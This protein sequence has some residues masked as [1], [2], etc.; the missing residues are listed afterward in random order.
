MP[1]TLPSMAGIGFSPVR[2]FARSRTEQAHSGAALA[3]P[4]SRGTTRPRGEPLD[5]GSALMPGLPGQ[6][7]L[8]PI[9]PFQP[10]LIP[11][12]AGVLAS[13]LSGSCWSAQGQHQALGGLSSQLCRGTRVCVCV[14][15]CA[16]EAEKC[17]CDRPA[18]ASKTLT[19]ALAL[20]VPPSPRSVSPSGCSERGGEGERT[21]GGRSG[22]ESRGQTGEAGCRALAVSHSLSTESA[23][24]QELWLEIR[25][26]CIPLALLLEAVTPL[27]TR[28]QT[29][30]V[31]RA[32]ERSAWTLP[33]LNASMCL[34]AW[35]GEVTDVRD[36]G[37]RLA[38][39]SPLT[40]SSR[41]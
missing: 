24:F 36:A 30:S 17:R 26:V 25:S 39:E 8:R 5:A 37:A 11:P 2:R 22:T 21:E 18:G 1:V 35:G 34:W 7:P 15:V 31:G 14:C 32:R 20:P 27:D 33:G 4:P 16:S 9:R 12:S 29:G 3:R 13:E 23:C 41:Q 6:H 40:V 10:H 19:M 28:T 38:A